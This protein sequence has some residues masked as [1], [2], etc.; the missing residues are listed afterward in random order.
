ML[1]GVWCTTYVL[2]VVAVAAVIS[3]SHTP[4]EA[5]PH[6]HA[7]QHLLIL[8]GLVAIILMGRGGERETT[9]LTRQ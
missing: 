6:V 9:M 1:L 8:L 5:S 4:H 2:Y 3:D 7:A